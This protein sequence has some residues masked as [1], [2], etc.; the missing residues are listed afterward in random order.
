MPVFRPE[1]AREIFERAA[2]HQ[3]VTAADQEVE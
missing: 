3:L 2:T 1:D